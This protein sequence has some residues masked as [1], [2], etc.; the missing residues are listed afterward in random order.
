M[1]SKYRDNSYKS[2]K[3]PSNFINEILSTDL[4]NYALNS[5]ITQVI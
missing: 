3:N 2:K 5:I 1:V 4:L